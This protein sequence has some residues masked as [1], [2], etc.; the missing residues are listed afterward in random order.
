[1][2]RKEL[3]FPMMTNSVSAVEKVIDKKIEE[4]KE[5]FDWITNEN[6]E[7]ADQMSTRFFQGISQISGDINIKHRQ[8][9]DRQNE[10][11]R[12]ADARANVEKCREQNPE[13]FEVIKAAAEHDR[14]DKDNW[15]DNY[16]IQPTLE[17][18]I[19]RIFYN[20]FWGWL[21]FDSICL[22]TGV[23]GAKE[24]GI[25]VVCRNR[26]PD[27]NGLYLHQ[28]TRQH[29]YTEDDLINAQSDVKLWATQT[30]KTFHTR[31]TC[32]NRGNSW[33]RPYQKTF[34]V[35]WLDGTPYDV[36]SRYEP[37]DLRR[38]ICKSCTKYAPLEEPAA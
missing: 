17:E 13:Y 27:S 20:H 1:M 4:I 15:T 21:D 19:D 22:G 18:M 12:W 6:L 26:Y 11:K 25:W 33:K 31:E 8:E 29:G 10:E 34:R 9:I 3:E 35:I 16:T 36:G 32:A 38:D 5:V 14:N 37:S 30:G 2:Q 23:E 28:I 24:D 7:L